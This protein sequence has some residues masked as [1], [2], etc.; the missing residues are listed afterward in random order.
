[1]ISKLKRNFDL[2]ILPLYSLSDRKEIK[3]KTN[4][5]WV[6][7]LKTLIFR[8]RIIRKVQSKLWLFN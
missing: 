4:I 1:M 8:V 6:S 2:F 7:D 5:R 3:S